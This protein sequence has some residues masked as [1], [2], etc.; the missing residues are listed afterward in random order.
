MKGNLL[1]GAPVAW[2]LFLLTSVSFTKW[3]QMTVH[4]WL[5]QANEQGMES[6]HIRLFYP[7]GQMS[8]LRYFHSFTNNRFNNVR[9]YA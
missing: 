5:N 9:I 3:A 4:S 7:K 1:W 6:S 2:M 8:R